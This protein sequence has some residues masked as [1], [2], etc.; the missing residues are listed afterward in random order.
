MKTDRRAVLCSGSVNN[1][2]QTVA[3]ICPDKLRGKKTNS[4]SARGFKQCDKADTCAFLF[5]SA[6]FLLSVPP[7]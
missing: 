7:V 5:R 6:G 2:T 4:N 3:R 1:N